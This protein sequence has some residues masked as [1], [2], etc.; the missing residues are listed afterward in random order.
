MTTSLLTDLSGTDAARHIGTEGLRNQRFGPTGRVVMSVEQPETHSAL[1]DALQRE[2]NWGP[3]NVNGGLRSNFRCEYC[4]KDLLASVD[5]Y[6]AWHMDHIVPLSRNGPHAF[7]HIAVC[8]GTC[9]YIK[10]AYMPE[11]S[12]R[13]EKVSDARR[14]VQE[15]R[16]R[17]LASLNQIQCLVGREPI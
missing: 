10:R 5:N 1:S 17:K 15:H 12:S 4:D 16:S 7:E 9:N 13:E 11:G 8:C 2:H 6:D 3:W 14:Y